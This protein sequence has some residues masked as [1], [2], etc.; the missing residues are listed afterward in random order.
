M[1]FI[2]VKNLFI[3]MSMQRIND[4]VFY[5]NITFNILKFNILHIVNY[6]YIFFI[7]THIIIGFLRKKMKLIESQITL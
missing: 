6:I 7:Y 4:F 3:S 5:Y 1:Y 2:N